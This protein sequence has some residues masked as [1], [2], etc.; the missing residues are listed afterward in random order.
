MTRA[1]RP[2]HLGGRRPDL[3]RR[4]M[5]GPPAPAGRPGRRRPRR[6]AP[7]SG[8]CAATSR[9]TSTRPPTTFDAARAHDWV[10]A[11]GRDLQAPGPA[12]PRP[13]V[14]PVAARRRSA[15]CRWC[16]P[17][18]PTRATRR[19]SGC[20]QR[21][22]GMKQARDHRPARRVP[23]RLRPGHRGVARPRLR[24]VAERAAPAARG[25]RHERHEV[26]DQRRPAAERA[27]RL[28]GRGLR[29]RERLG[30][31]GRGRRRPSGPGRARRRRPAPSCSTTRSCR[32]STSATARSCRRP[33]CARVRASLKTLA[34]RFSATRMLSEYL[35]GPYRGA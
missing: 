33:G 6:A 32:C 23:R 26:G 3:R 35:A 31:P 10:R 8:C 21:L 20:S 14:D 7:P 18:R 4:A 27:R 22:F 12:D 28:V 29:R 2:R 1:G 19:P 11:P 13:R 17:A 16:S 5:A 24:R 15:R 34:P 25:E 9:T 30:D